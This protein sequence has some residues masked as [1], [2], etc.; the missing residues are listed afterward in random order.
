MKSV[1]FYQQ[2]LTLSACD[3][4]QQGRLLSP[5]VQW[6]TCIL[7]LLEGSALVAPLLCYVFFSSLSLIQSQASRHS[8]RLW[9][10]RKV[11]TTSRLFWL[12]WLAAIRLAVLWFRLLWYAASLHP[13]RE[14]H[15]CLEKVTDSFGPGSHRCFTPLP[16]YASEAFMWALLPQSSLK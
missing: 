4:S 15:G 10:V 3:S 7:L 9:N 2:F 1:L 5:S 14:K 13:S 16:F 11:C 6:P 12:M 8:S